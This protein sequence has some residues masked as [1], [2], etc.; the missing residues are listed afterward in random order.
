MGIEKLKHRTRLLRFVLSPGYLREDLRLHVNL[1]YRR[2][3]STESGIK[4]KEVESLLDWDA[5][6]VKL[7]RPSTNDGSVSKLE[8]LILTAFAR[9][10]EPGQHFL[11]I[12]TWDG[13]TAL[14]VALNLRTQDI[15]K[16]PAQE[17]RHNT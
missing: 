9:T 17:Y 3:L 16:W 5:V 12:G 14:N 10:L 11:E 8:L 1:M 4:E 13:K 2:R 15:T 7:S 6:E